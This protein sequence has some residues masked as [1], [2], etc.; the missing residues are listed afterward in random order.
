MHLRKDLS[1]ILGKRFG[2]RAKITELQPQV[3]GF[4]S[5][6]CRDLNICVTIF[7]IKAESAFYPYE[8]GK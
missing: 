5:L 4:D 8:I 1:I 7:S 2:L 6:F 3:P